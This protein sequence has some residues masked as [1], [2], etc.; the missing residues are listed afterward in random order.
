MSLPTG[1]EY[2][3]ALQ[4]PSS[5]LSEPV[6]QSCLVDCNQMGQPMSW[7]GSNAIVFRL[8][9]PDGPIL[10][11]RCFTQKVP[12]VEL[13]YRA[14]LDFYKQ[15]PKGLKSALVG[16]QYLAKGIQVPGAA[17]ALWQPVIVMTWANGQHLGGWVES[18]R[19]DKVKLS[20]LQG[21]LGKLAAEMGSAHFVHGDVQHRNI[22]VGERGPVLV[23]Y[24]SV[25]LPG[26]NDLKLTTQGLA[27]FRHPRAITST[28]PEAL[29]RF[30]FLV[31]H[32]GLEALIRKPELYE[33]WGKV[34]GLLFQGSDLRDPEV[35]PLFQALRGCPELAGLAQALAN[36]C[37]AAPS[38]TPDLRTFLTMAERATPV[39]C[40]ATAMPAWNT[41]S[42]KKLDRLYAPK[43]KEQPCK[44][45]NQ[46]MKVQWWI[47]NEG[48]NHS[49]AQLP[50]A[51]TAASAA[52]VTAATP[53]LRSWQAPRRS[54]FRLGPILGV[55]ALAAMLAFAWRPIHSSTQDAPSVGIASIRKDLQAQL[56]AKKDQLLPLI[57]SMDDELEIIRSL[58]DDLHL[59]KLDPAKG[60]VEAHSAAWLRQSLAGTREQARQALLRC[61]GVLV[62][63]DTTLRDSQL[64]PAQQAQ[65][66]VLIQ[67]LPPGIQSRIKRD[68]LERPRP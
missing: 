65:R 3:K 14:Y 42:L 12:D 41:P 60:T 24:D 58:P 44:P 31:L 2:L 55:L 56:E 35:S 22:V 13:R 19:G 63:F 66:L 25:I 6:L 54:K 47:N 27:A 37:R 18:H 51:P 52:A 26:A 48:P 1:V 45:K 17:G 67:D 21:K 59:A 8:R 32:V 23:D 36:V 62:D 57:V 7:A 68:L 11:L 39:S 28:P 4:I 64:T 49:S 43:P 29:D 46:P 9:L 50:I 5:S 40:S 30:A 53:I 15:A 34:E 33:R 10:A 61:D 16:V 38:K 20:W